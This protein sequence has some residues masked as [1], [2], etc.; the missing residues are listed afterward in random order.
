MKSKKMRLSGGELLVGSLVLA[1]V[2]AGSVLV[3]PNVAADNS[4][5]D[6]VQINVQTSCT[7]TGSGNGTYAVELINGQKDENIGNTTL[8]AYCNDENGFAIYAVG[9]GDDE[10][11]DTY[12]HHNAD[13]SNNFN[14]GTTFS[15]ATSAWAF[16][17]AAI[18]GQYTPQITSGYTSFHTVP[19]QYTMV[20]YRDDTQGGSQAYAEDPSTGQVTSIGSQLT[21]TYGVYVSGTQ[22]PGTYTGKVRYALVHPYSSTSLIS[23][24]KA[25][26]N[27]SAPTRTI[28]DKT[29]YT[30]QGMTANI[31]ASATII[32][33]ASQ[34]QL[35]D[36]RDNKLYWVT[37]LEDGHCWMTQNL[38]LDLK[39]PNDTGYVALTNQNTDLNECVSD[40]DG[41][42]GAYYYGYSTDDGTCSNSSIVWI[43]G[44]STINSS[45]GDFSG[46]NETQ[47]SP[48]SFDVGLWYTNGAYHNSSTCNYLSGTGCANFSQ[49]PYVIN[50]THGAVGNYYNWT[51]AIASS[52]SS[53]LTSNTSG[54]INNNPKNSICPK[55]WRLPT[56]SSASGAT[57]GSTSEFSR[58][59]YIYNHNYTSTGDQGRD[60]GLF[61]APLY[62]NRA[63]RV[64]SDALNYPG[65]SGNFWSSTVASSSFAFYLY[66][67]ST[68]VN[69]ADYNSRYYG[70][71]VRC[72][73]R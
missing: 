48:Q 61:V 60:Q 15:G 70:R 7:L 1:T 10:E 25:L 55:G 64:D 27:A 6:Q 21:A 56:I 5:V 13:S 45:N 62:F 40:P 65:Y 43:P 16:K 42:T 57:P 28:G 59:N 46:W 20:A 52:N 23:L 35:V 39:R 33:E 58:L 26:E 73:A 66:F 31:C 38:D 24:K 63:G 29:Y 2:F 17:L 41:Y 11:G 36:T 68:Y 51:A 18:T 37:K 14:T 22:A 3:I 49:T 19:D 50:G 72:L 34:V 4:A 8:T 9:A 54:N 30:M 44:Q 67:Y 12:M 32:G 69:P 53:N 47:T 71:S